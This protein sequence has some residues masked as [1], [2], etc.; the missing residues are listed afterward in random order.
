MPDEVIS[1]NLGQ[2][3]AAFGPPVLKYSPASRCTHAAAKSVLSSS[4]AIMWLK[5]A[6]HDKKSFRNRVEKR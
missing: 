3:V 1:S 4:S 5:C 2:L 6:L